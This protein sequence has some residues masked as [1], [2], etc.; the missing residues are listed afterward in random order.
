MA[1]VISPVCKNNNETK[2][3]LV[4]YDERKNWIQLAHVVAP[5][6]A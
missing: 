3:K 2:K 4:E 1:W 6:N 5:A